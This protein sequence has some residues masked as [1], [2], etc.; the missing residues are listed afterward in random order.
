MPSQLV[1]RIKDEETS[2]EQTTIVKR[3]AE[4]SVKLE[5]GDYRRTVMGKASGILTE[6]K[7]IP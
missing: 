6:L 3:G 5:V 1:I 2:I 7:A 4:R